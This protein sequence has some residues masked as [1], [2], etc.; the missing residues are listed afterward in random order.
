M[1]FSLFVNDVLAFGRSDRRREAAAPS[2]PAVKE[3]SGTPPLPRPAM[4]D[5]QAFQILYRRT[6]GPL[7][8]YAARVIGNAANADDIVQESYLRL[9]RSPPPTE[10]PQQLRAWLF[11]IASRLIVDQWRRGRFEHAQ[12]IA[13]PDTL[14]RPGPDIPLRVDMARVFERLNP[15]Q[16]QLMWL[17]YVEGASHREIADALDIREASVRVLLHRTR[18][19]LAGFL[20]EGGHGAP[21]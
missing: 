5:E 19:K 15:Q 4:L 17:A 10:D 9:V 8:A 11:R 12:H 14:G 16:R 3:A 7:R 1:T 6:A 18:R 13:M 21:L 20:R 2:S